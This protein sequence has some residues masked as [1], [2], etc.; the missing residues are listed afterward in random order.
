MNF[1]AHAYLAGPLAADR[2][3]GVIGDFVKGRLEPLPPGLDAELAAGVM[4][5]RRIDSFAE[6][7]P[8]FRRSRARVSTERRRL[9]GI[10][11]DLFYDHFL[12]RRWSRFSPEPLAE[13]TAQTYRLIGLYRGP[14]PESFRPVFE[15]MA[16]HDW[17]ASYR[18]ADNVARALDRMAEHR[19]RRPNP[20]AGAG[21]ELLR[22]YAGFEADF[23][24]FLPDARAY[25]ESVRSARAGA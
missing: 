18:D 13:F 8:A 1:L 15:R 2:I 25:A 5:H 21:E 9:G 16:A 10:M 4:L 14:L 19:L 23:L 11:V 22:G 12:A 6:T 17:L 20:L 7:H 3:G 24:E